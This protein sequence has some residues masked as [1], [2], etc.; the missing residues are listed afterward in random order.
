MLGACQRDMVAKL[1]MVP[2]TYTLSTQGAETGGRQVPGQLGYIQRPCLNKQ[3]CL[4]L[5]RLM[6]KDTQ[7]SSHPHSEFQTNLQ[8]ELHESLSQKENKA[9]SIH[10]ASILRVLIPTAQI[11]NGM[12][13]GPNHD[14]L[15]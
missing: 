1:S 10:A 2:H 5:R 14:K 13:T 6:Q 9:K 11:S 4:A 15:N 7:G 3:K 8:S 12:I